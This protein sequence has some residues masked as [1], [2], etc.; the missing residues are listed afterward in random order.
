MKT[1][2]KDDEMLF[3]LKNYFD[4]PKKF[5]QL[6]DSNRN[7]SI[8]GSTIMSLLNKKEYDNSDIDIYIDI[9]G[10]T[11]LLHTFLEEMH[12]F[13]LSEE[14]IIK[15][16]VREGIHNVDLA[17][18]EIDKFMY[19]PYWGLRDYIHKVIGYKSDYHST[20]IDFIFIK[21][22]IHKMI[23]ESFDMDIVKNYYCMGTIYSYFYKS[24]ICKKATITKDHFIKRICRGSEYEK[25]KFIHRYKKY[26]RRGFVIYI[27]SIKVDAF[28]IKYFYR[29]RFHHDMEK[30]YYSFIIG[31]SIENYILR[32]RIYRYIMIIKNS[33]ITRN[34]LLGFITDKLKGCK[35]EDK[36]SLRSK[37]R[38]YLTNISLKLE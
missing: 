15:K 13:V 23:V 5:K 19:T 26:T 35:I 4:N 9:S 17:M 7:I 18:N 22:P 37:K 12:C 29:N 38:R 31:K 28:F 25:N 34:P 11:P 20:S 1:F 27:D 2:N 3:M 14:Y 8:S 21:M 16:G 33:M 32:K 6:I 36:D 24:I 30:V 10:I